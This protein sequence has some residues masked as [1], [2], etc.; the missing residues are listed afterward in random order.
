MD[1]IGALAS[2][3]GVVLLVAVFGVV[4]EAAWGTVGDWRR[5]RRK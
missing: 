5:Y 3:A 1:L 4:L 2:V